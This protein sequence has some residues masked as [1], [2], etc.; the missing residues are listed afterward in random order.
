MKIISLFKRR[1]SA[2]FSMAEAV[3]AV[4][5]GSVAIAGGMTLSQQNL[6]LVKSVRE[7]N[8]ASM[9][10]EERIEQ[11]RLANWRQITN[12]EYLTATYFPNKPKSAR[13]LDGVK[14][15]VSVTAFPDATACTPLIIERDHYGS[16]QMLSNGADLDTQH[17][18]R[19]NVRVTW[20]GKDGRV[21]IRELASIISNAGINRNSLPLTGA[22]SGSGTSTTTTGTTTEGTTT[23]GTTTTTTTTTTG[24]GNGN[25]NGGSQGNVAGKTGKK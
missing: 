20:T 3:V 23:G 6:R 7:T 8:A 17:L 13:T 5:I 9:A 21:R 19:V 4:A 24:N 14:E 10:L 15:R 12:P 1:R 2:G 18:A 25:G 11:L 16:P 22:D